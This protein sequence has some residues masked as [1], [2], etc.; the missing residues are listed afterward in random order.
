MNVDEAK[1]VCPDFDPIQL[2]GKIRCAHI[3]NNDTCSHKKH[4]GICRLVRVKMVGETLP[5]TNGLSLEE[6]RSKTLL[7]VND[8]PNRCLLCDQN[9]KAY[10]RKLYDSMAVGL[11]RIYKR[12]F[13]NDE[14]IHIPS[15]F[16]DAKICSAN[17]GSLLRHWG[18]IERLQSERDDG[19]DRVGFY[20][21]T[22]LG[23]AF[24]EEDV[25]IP[26]HAYLYN[27]ILLGLDPSEKVSIKEALG[28]RFSYYELMR[29]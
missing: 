4:K 26:S 17:D 23:R 21:I 9:A 25:R 14:W 7:G 8:H 28:K 10:R 18:L 3:R 27:Q 13:K 20:R 2:Q 6:A 15:M 1:Q 24:A 5:P 11:I 12:N 19:S 29:G 16:R 22:D